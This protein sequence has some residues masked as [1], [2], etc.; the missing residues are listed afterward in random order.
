MCVYKFYTFFFSLRVRYYICIYTALI[1]YATDETRKR[2]KEKKIT[3]NIFLY[4][5]E[6]R[7]SSRRRRRRRCGRYG[8]FSRLAPAHI[9]YVG[10]APFQRVLYYVRVVVAV[11][12]FDLCRASTRIIAFPIRTNVMRLDRV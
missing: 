1:P 6:I 4:I 5:C 8:C 7:Y 2:R 3:L 12:V 9:C 11:A 10:L